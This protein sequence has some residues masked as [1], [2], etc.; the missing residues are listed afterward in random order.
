MK[1]LKVKNNELEKIIESSREKGY[2]SYETILEHFP[3][4][5]NDMEFLE[6]L[7]KRLLKE[8]I[9]IVY[10]QN[11]ELEIDAK[12]EDDREMSFEEK[13]KK[14]KRLKST[15]NTDPVKIYLS[16]V[17]KKP[18]LNKEEEVVLA[19]RIENGD[20]EARD[21]LA[22]ANLRL[23]LS[24]ARKYRGN[25]VDFIDLIQEGNMGLLKA[26]EKFEYKKGYKFSTYAT[27]WIRQYI[28]RSLANNS[29]T[30]RIPV[31]LH[32][33]WNK[34]RKEANKLS[35]KFGRKAK[36]S[37]IA[38]ELDMEVDDVNKVIR[39]NKTPISLDM[40]IGEDG[41][42]VLSDVIADEF[43]TSPSDLT[44]GTLLRKRVDDML[45]GL[46][47]RERKILKMRFG[48]EDGVT[49][50]LREIGEEFNVTRERIR[51]IEKGALEK[52]KVRNKKVLKKYLD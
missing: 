11:D 51:Q 1:K 20:R 26:I 39:L 41:N 12:E 15:L 31:H 29:R 7:V 24:I 19:K 28:T 36:S 6:H 49:R 47:D 32:E 13:I 42:R 4:V 17:G 18:L 5:E 22:V 23:V 35:T 2:V 30:I 3:D 40:Q 48:L 45:D 8:R 38:R 34:I 46:K 37:E 50:T 25:G 10:D 27:W 44:E 9:E 14:I 43:S 21:I 52:L 16:E 33:T